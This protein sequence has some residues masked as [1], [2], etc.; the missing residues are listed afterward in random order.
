[1]YTLTDKQ[2]WEEKYW[3]FSQACSIQSYLQQWYSIR[4][5]WTTKEYIYLRLENYK[6]ELKHRMNSNINQISAFFS[7]LDFLLYVWFFHK[8]PSC[9]I[10]FSNC[11]CKFSFDF[12]VRGIYIQVMQVSISSKTIPP[13]TNPRDVTWREP[14]SSPGTIIVYKSPPLGTKQGVKRFTPGT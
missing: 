13:G 1:M 10:L 7:Q 2:F 4:A 5:L 9:N 3:I 12:H 6:F 11:T 14:K 8:Q